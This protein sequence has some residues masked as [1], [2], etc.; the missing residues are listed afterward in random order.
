MIVDDDG[1]TP[2]HLAISHRKTTTK[3]LLTKYDHSIKETNGCSLLHLVCQQGYFELVEQL[4]TDY[5]FNPMIFDDNGNTPLHY[6]ALGG[7]IKVANLLINKFGFLINHQN[8]KKETPLHLACTKGHVIFIQ[9]LMTEYK[10]DIN[11]RDINNQTPLQR[12]VLSGQAKVID[13][14]IKEF[15]CSANIKGTNGC[16]LLHLACQQGHLELI[17]QLVAEYKLDP[18]IVDDDGNTPL[19]Y[20]ALSGKNEVASTLLVTEYSSPVNHPNNNNEMPLHLACSRGH[21]AFIQT[22]VTEYTADINACDINDHT[23]LYRAV[24]SGQAKV[25]DCMI[26]EFNCSANIKGTNGCSLLHLACQ[27]GH[28]E[29]IEQLVTEYKLDPMIVD[30]D[31]NTPLH[32]AALSGKSELAAML[33]IKYHSAVNHPNNNIET[34]LYLACSKGHLSFIQTLVT[35]YAAD[36]NACDINGHTPLLR[37]ALSGQAKVIDCLIKEFNCSAD[38]KGTNG[39]SLLHLACQQGHLELIEQLVA[40]YK[41]DPMIVDD[42]GNTPLHYAALSGKNEVA[43]ILIVK[44]HSAINHQNCKMETPLHLACTKGHLSFIQTFVTQYSAD[45]DIC[46][47]KNHTPLQRAALSGETKVVCSFILKFSC[48]PN[49]TG[50]QGRN[51]L[52]YACLNGHDVLAKEL[53]DS[54]HLSLIS[55]DDNGNSPLH[56]SAMFGQIKCVYMLLHTYNAPVYLRNNSGKSALEITR[57]SGIKKTINTYLKEEHNKIQ[58]DYRIVQSLSSKK[59]SGAQKLTR[60]FV[61]GN[62][63]SGKSTVVESLKRNGFFSSWNPVSEATVPPHTSGI[64]PS[65]YLHRSIGRVLYY[66]FAGDPEYYSSHSAIMISVIQ[67]K[68]GTNVCL[69]LVNFQKSAEHIQEELGYWFTFIAYH[70]VN[71]REKCEVLTIGS[72]IDRISKAEAKQKVALVSQFTQKYLSHTPKASFEVVKKCLTL[73]CRKP[74]SSRHI[75]TILNEIVKRASTFRLSVEAAIILGLLEKDFKNV[76]TCKLHTLV[77]H[78]MDTGVHLPTTANFL[79]P[80]I[81]EL[82]ALGLLMIINS[83]NG[84]LEDNLLLLDVPKLTNKVHKIIFSK[85]S[86]QQFPPCNHSHGVSMGILPQT[87]LNDI[88]PEYITSECLIQLQYCQEFSHAEVKFDSVVPTED[89]SAPKL[90]Y[91]PALCETERK[92]NVETPANYDYSIG[93][94]VKCIGEFDYL[95][96]RFLHVLLLRLAHTFALP[97]T[98]DPQPSNLL[99]VVQLYNRRCTMWKNGIHWFMTKGIECFVE[100]VNNSKGIVIITKSEEARKSV[101]T[102]MLFEIIREIRQAKEEFCKTVMLKEHFMNSDDPSSFVD[103]TKLYHANDIAKELKE[104]NPVIVST[105]EQGRTQISAAIVS[106]LREYIHWG[107]YWLMIKHLR[108]AIYTY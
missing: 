65:E 16:S 85:N 14:M 10:A 7:R 32:Y 53:I 70:C 12:A 58:S 101:C 17:E 81:M 91:F 87:Y 96:P 73:N 72:H 26:K 8:S 59:Y 107:E 66:D 9:T 52:H 39:C 29:L 15:N 106:H 6:A 54:F 30:D 25:I 27:Q 13:C 84:K 40:E 63:Q 57:D 28:L 19:H 1:N 86:V 42:D 60:V 68:Q 89:S 97:A 80:I 82:H 104:G 4:V 3:L 77:S 67:S 33:I 55:V 64:I 20:A 61:L 56:I 35:E 47:V 76:V 34:P 62:V 2:L 18:M 51:L 21:L 94:Y 36:I 49:V 108:L 22:L 90:L 23:P 102:D 75:Y 92:N 105:D 83:G 98:C 43:N 74:R 50:D 24:L 38:I 5:N 71:L 103:K 11:T 69:I 37:A 45:I 99:D 46:D 93:W 95:P 48:D 100:N 31:G 41:L 78:I 88:L 44:Y 79:H